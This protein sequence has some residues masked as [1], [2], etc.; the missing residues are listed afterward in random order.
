MDCSNEFL[1]TKIEPSSRV[2]AKIFV[3][4]PSLGKLKHFLLFFDFPDVVTRLMFCDCID[5]IHFLRSKL[6][7][8]VWFAYWLFPFPKSF[9]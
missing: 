7:H 5:T 2:S 6:S 1:A 4:M 8:L 3:H 9:D